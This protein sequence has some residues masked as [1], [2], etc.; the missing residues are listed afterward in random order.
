MAAK[1]AKTERRGVSHGKCEAA[2]RIVL[3]G[4][5]KGDQLTK[6][7]GWYNY[8]V[9][10]GELKVESGELNVESGKCGT[11]GNSQLSTLNFQLII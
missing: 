2:G 6:W 7:R 4:T 10:S 8:P 1:K 11:D 9:K 5:Y 3:V